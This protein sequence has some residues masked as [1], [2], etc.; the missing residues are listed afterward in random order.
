[1]DDIATEV[2]LA[3]MIPVT[4]DLAPKVDQLIEEGLSIMIDE[5]QTS[6]ILHIL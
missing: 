4:G 5:Y 2:A 6:E 1:M 3:S